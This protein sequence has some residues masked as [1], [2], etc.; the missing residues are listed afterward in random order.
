MDRQEKKWYSYR[1]DERERERE[2]GERDASFL[3]GEKK[4]YR[5]EKG[6]SHAKGFWDEYDGNRCYAY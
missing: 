4:E 6:Y 1:V 5:R 3:L 2:R